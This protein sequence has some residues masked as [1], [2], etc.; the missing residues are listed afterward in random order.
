MEENLSVAYIMTWQFI[1][2]N[3]FNSNFTVPTE[4]FTISFISAVK[5]LFD[6]FL[7]YTYEYRVVFRGTLTIRFIYVI[8]S[9]FD[10]FDIYT[11]W[12]VLWLKVFIA[13]S[14]LCFMRFECFIFKS[15][16]SDVYNAS[17]SAEH[18]KKIAKEKKCRWWMLNIK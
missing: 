7:T 9:F 6:V 15:F 2:I 17:A 1:S 16:I 13:E 11:Y 12:V 3:G 10:V 8:K 14:H 5:Y 18:T 4:T